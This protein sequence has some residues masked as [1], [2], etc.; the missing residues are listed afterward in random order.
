VCHNNSKMRA[1]GA[2]TTYLTETT[3]TAFTKTQEST[4]SSLRPKKVSRKASTTS[5]TSTNTNTLSNNRVVVRKVSN[6]L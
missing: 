4:L 2:K 5:T 1:L 6:I 3:N